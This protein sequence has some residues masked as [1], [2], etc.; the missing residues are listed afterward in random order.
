MH[1]RPAEPAGRD[2]DGV[3]DQPH[4][5]VEVAVRAN[6]RVD[7]RIPTARGGDL[8]QNAPTSVRAGRCTG[9]RDRGPT[10]A[11]LEGAQYFA[12]TGALPF[13]LPHPNR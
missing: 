9:W 13:P 10:Q 12:T 4:G 3:S 8:A 5:S 2:H 7:A 1:D 6:K 11:G